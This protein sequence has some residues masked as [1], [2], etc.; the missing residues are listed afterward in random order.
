MRHVEL[1]LENEEAVPEW[2]LGGSS[3][4]TIHT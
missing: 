4:G 3:R 1:N 2:V